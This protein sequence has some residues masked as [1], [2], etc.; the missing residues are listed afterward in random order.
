MRIAFVGAVEFSRECLEE[1]LV[2]GGDVIAVLTLAAERAG[3]HGDYADLGPVAASHGVPVHRIGN[4]NDPAEIELIR[5]LHPDVIFVFGWSQLL[6]PELLQLAPCIGSHPTLLP[7]NRGRHPLTWALVEG[8]E[9]SG[10]TFL[11]LDGDADTGD[12]LWQRAFPIEIE[13]DAATVYRRVVR[14]GR[15]A[16][17]EFLPALES[18]SAPRLPQNEALATYWRKTGTRRRRSCTTSF[19]ASRARTSE[20]SPGAPGRMCSCGG[21]TFPRNPFP[22]KRRPRFPAR[23]SQT[24]RSSRCAPATGI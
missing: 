14:L 11:W 1:T 10:L 22:S 3:F 24:R 21:L 15:E 16:I 13:D 19:G 5:S 7:R 17:R 4:I 6:G 23:F 20:R 12:I 2:T 9:Q 8:L 18:G